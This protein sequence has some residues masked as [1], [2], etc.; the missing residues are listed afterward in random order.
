MIISDSL[1]R[2]DAVIPTHRA[3][4][5]GPCDIHQYI[6]YKSSHCAVVRAIRPQELLLWHVEIN[7]LL[8]SVVGMARISISANTVYWY[9][10][11]SLKPLKR[12]D[13]SYTR[14]S[15][16]SSMYSIQTCDALSKF[17]II[18]REKSCVAELFEWTIMSSNL[19]MTILKF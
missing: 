6:P 14:H 4:L 3:Y 2:S 1:F 12:M 10:W 15:C 5:A 16:N 11:F 9:I 7:K 8:R 13:I 17:G 19:I 18:S